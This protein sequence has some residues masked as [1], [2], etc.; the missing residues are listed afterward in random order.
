MKKGKVVGSVLAPFF[1]LAL[2]VILSNSIVI[3]Q[4]DEYKIL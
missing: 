2:V 1:I 4:H 3:T